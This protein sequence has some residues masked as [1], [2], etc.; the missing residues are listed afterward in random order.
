MARVCEFGEA[1]LEPHIEWPIPDNHVLVEFFCLPIQ[2]FTRFAVIPPT[3]KQTSIQRCLP[4][5][6]PLKKGCKQGTIIDAFSTEEVK[7]EHNEWDPDRVTAFYNDMKVKY[8]VHT[9]QKITDKCRKVANAFL[10]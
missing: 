10:K 5:N 8:N 2:N 7:S 1:A 9:A 4:F 3:K 6:A